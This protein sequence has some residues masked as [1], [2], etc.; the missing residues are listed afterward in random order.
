VAIAIARLLWS[1]GIGRIAAL[2]VGFAAAEWLRTFVFTGFPWNPVGQAAMPTPLLMQSVGI[3]SMTGM[4]LLAVF[5]FAIPAALISASGRKAG[6]I[7]AVIIAAL[8]VG[9]GAY[10]LGTAEKISDKL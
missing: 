4:N 10:R 8:H 2:A 7:V 1:D 9:Y 5:V 3:V 6:V